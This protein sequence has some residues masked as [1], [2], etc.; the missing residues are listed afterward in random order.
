MCSHYTATE[1]LHV[2]G[3][4]RFAEGPSA[5]GPGLFGD[6]LGGSALPSDPSVGNF[7]G[8]SHT[9][10]QSI[11]AGFDYTLSNTLLTDFRFGYMRY[12]VQTTPGGAGTSP[13][14]DAGI[15]GL[16]QGDAYTT[17][18]PAFQINEP[19]GAS[20]FQFG[21]SLDI[22]QCNC[23]LLESEHQYQFVNNWTKIRG[24]HSFKFGV[25]LRRAYNLRVPSDLS[26]CRR[27]YLQQRHHSWPVVSRAIRLWFGLVLPRYYQH[28]H[29]ICQRLNGCLRDAGALLL[30][31][32]RHVAHHSEVDGELRIAMG[33]I[34]AGG[35][36]RHR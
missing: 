6:T 29:S 9:K 16:N 15:P 35:G 26:S 2:F 5:L 36:G 21:Y 23:P 27:A 14:S 8:S 19:N 20:T 11:A 34:Q 31:R 33:N 10:N 4:H 22:N 30:L 28:L 17:G 1:K 32:A 13:A 24:N 3:R 7:A 25:D 12:H 18:M